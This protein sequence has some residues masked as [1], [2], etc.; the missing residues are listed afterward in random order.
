MFYRIRA[1]AEGRYKG[2][3]SAKLA[4]GLPFSTRKRVD[5]LIT[6]ADGQAEATTPTSSL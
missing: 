6:G 1:Y 2:L 5:F 4:A 3:S